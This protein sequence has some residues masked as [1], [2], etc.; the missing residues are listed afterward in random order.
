VTEYLDIVEENDNYRV[1]LAYD[2][3]GE[4]PYDEGGVPILSREFRGMRFE[5]VN[6]QANEYESVINELWDRYDEET[7][8]R[9]LRIFLGATS[10]IFNSSENQRYL[11]F[12]TAEWREKMGLTDE[13]LE[14]HKGEH[15][16]DNLAKGTMDEY[17]AWANG[18]VYGYIVE[19]KF[20][21]QTKY[22]DPVTE[23]LVNVEDDEEW[24]PVE[25]GSVWGFFGREWAEQAAREALAE[26]MTE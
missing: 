8:E 15:D 21:T 12:D 7:I 26:A 22:I 17:M 19:K 1:R 5:A 25:D 3:S 24:V 11:A 13:Y 16:F 14:A 6:D 9:F 18:E 2:D 20:T 23:E 4:K 10:V